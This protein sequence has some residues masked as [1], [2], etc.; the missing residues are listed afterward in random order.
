MAIGHVQRK[1]LYGRTLFTVSSEKPMK[2]T[3]FSFF[4]I[5]F[6]KKCWQS[7]GINNHGTLQYSSGNGVKN[8]AKLNVAKIKERLEKGPDF[9]DFVQGNISGKEKWKDYEGKIIREKGG[10]RLR[11]PPWLKTEIPI[12]KNFSKLKEN[13]RGLNLHTV[14]EEARCPNIGEC[15]GGGPDATATAT[16]MVWIL[17]HLCF[18]AKIILN[19]AY[20]WYLYTW[21]QIL[22]SENIKSTTSSWSQWTSQYS[23]SHCCLG[24]WLCCF[25][26][27][28]PRWY[29]KL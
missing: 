12:G 22:F 16:I 3:H 18:S 27:C 7:S 19:T 4:M 23:N 11:L 14:C 26:I 1:L 21:L 8:S 17:L 6:P 24:T 29:Y 5:I 25:D 10:Q 9:S 28:G 15:W 13:L 2:C 20:G